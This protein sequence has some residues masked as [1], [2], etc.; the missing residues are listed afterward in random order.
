MPRLRIVVSVA[1]GYYW[2]LGALETVHS[3]IAY[4]IFP[5]WF[6][7]FAF[8]YLKLAGWRSKKQKPLDSSRLS[9][10]L[11]NHYSGQKAPLL[12]FGVLW[13]IL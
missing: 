9:P 3:N 1:A 7:L 5:L 12:T 4:V 6:A 13:A 2:G 10:P 8:V 11:L